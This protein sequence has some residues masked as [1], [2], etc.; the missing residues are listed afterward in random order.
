MKKGSKQTKK[1]I[2]VV[3]DDHTEKIDDVAERMKK[4]G[5]RIDQVL[6]FTGI[7]TGTTPDLEK[8]NSVRGIK[9][10]EEDRENKAL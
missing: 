1:F 5:A 9:S 3:E 4:E 2:A 7:I 8:L 10:V 6:S